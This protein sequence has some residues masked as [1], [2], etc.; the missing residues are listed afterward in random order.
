MLYLPNYAGSLRCIGQSLQSQNIEVFE[1]KFNVN[2]FRLQCGDPNPPY[3]GLV[4][5]KFSIDDIAILDRE[6]QARRGQLSTEIRF[7]SLPEILRAIGE[8]IDSKRGM[9]QR[10]S[11]ICTANLDNR[12]LE[13]E[14]EN[15]AGD[16][17]SE[18]LTLSFIR[19]I[20][21]HMYKKRTRLSNPIGFLTRQR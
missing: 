11:N 1:L 15:R 8:Y 9:L 4:D 7:D 17:Q 18:T 5:L 3:T 2:E 10:I 14:Y 12:T 21:V 13:S 19:E 6:G 20:A 16:V